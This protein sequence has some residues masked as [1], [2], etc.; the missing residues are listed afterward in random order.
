MLSM[1][2]R[3]SIVV[4]IAALLSYMHITNNLEEQLLGELEKYIAE[5]AAKESQIF[6][7]AEDNHQIFRDRYLSLWQSRQ[8][9]SS[10]QRFNQLFEP[11]KEGTYQLT[12][13][14]YD[15][16]T[17]KHDSQADY[18][19]SSQW[20]SGFIGKNTPV[21][22]NEFRNR[23]LLSYDLVDH[24]SEAWSNRFANTY[25]SLP[26]GVNIVYWPKLNWAAGADPNLDIPAEEWV[27]IANKTHNPERQSVWTGLYYDQTADSWM[28]SCETPVD[29]KN[30][31]HLINIGH[32]I[33]LD[34]LF[35]RVFNDTLAGAYNYIIR[36]DGRLV[37]HPHFTA[38]LQQRLGL[39]EVTGLQESAI[40]E[41]YQLITEAIEQSG[42]QAQIVEATLESGEKAFLA[43]A[44]VDGPDWT[45]VTVY[46]QA[47]LYSSAE[48]SAR[49]IFILGLVS[50]VIELFI[51][52]LVMRKQVTSPIQTI[53][54]STKAIEQK[55]FD[56]K[57]ILRES[58]LLE[59]KDEVGQL[60]RAIVDMAT[61]MERYHHY[62]EHEVDK[63]TH[64]LQQAREYAEQLAITDD[65]TGLPNRRAFFKYAE[66]ALS[67]ASTT[68]QAITVI[69]IDID[70]FKK[71][72]DTFGHSAGDKVLLSLA[73]ILKSSLRPSDLPA[74]IGGEEFAVVLIDTDLLSGMKVA[75][76]LRE[77]IDT[78]EILHEGNVI[79]TTASFGV[80]ESHTT[81]TLFSELLNKADKA[82]YQAKET[83]RNKVV[84][85]N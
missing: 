45:F 82:L 83:G 10:E 25:V 8:N 81:A 7:L 17:R 62:L 41:Q 77:K 18:V 13:K 24:F 29:D 68:G 60:S 39:L 80:A 55:S 14:A 37:A 31:H 33:L 28:V 79:Q 52:Y 64:E 47:L 51:L 58:D 67:Q 59:R 56:V 23:V 32:D 34:K 27:Y 42:N 30:G 2:I 61:E 53:Q 40:L 75:E 22:N 57:P 63:R 73:E 65:L 44:N 1:G 35:E 38:E 19:G 3:I 16:L 54:Q 20:I 74:R 43:F 66:E 11:Y 9:A 46:P 48:A 69:M 50:L 78:S 72:N 5:R 12:Q 15:G 36:K 26:E 70:H 49:F 85:Q 6:Q 76:K 4:T 21:D 84:V 71:V